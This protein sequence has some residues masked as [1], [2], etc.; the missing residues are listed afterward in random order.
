M[1]YADS[2]IYVK[3]R[4]TDM[5]EQEK[6]RIITQLMYHSA[7]RVGIVYDF[8]SLCSG[9]MSVSRM[10]KNGCELTVTEV[11]YILSIVETPGITSAELCRK[12]NR[13]RGAVSQILKKLEQK[14]LIYREKQVDSD[15]NGIG[16][17]TTQEGFRIAMEVIANERED[18]NRLFHT[19]L[20]KGCTKEELEGFYRVMDVYISILQNDEAGSWVELLPTQVEEK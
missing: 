3:E 18:S 4:Q 15:G 5:S 1:P 9:M 11:N 10:Y 12:W 14:N 6:K 17:Y 20:D 7:H 19:L 2:L 13:T 16:L 8:A